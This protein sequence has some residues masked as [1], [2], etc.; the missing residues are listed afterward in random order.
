MGLY[1][2]LVPLVVRDLLRPLKN[3]ANFLLNLFLRIES[4][5]R[6]LS[7]PFSGM[8]FH[9]PQLEYAMLL[10]TW[11]LEL[12][13]VWEKIL[14]TNFPLMV[15]VGAAEGYYA[16][17]MAYRKPDAKVVAYEMDDRVRKNLFAL[18][19]ANQVN[20]EVHGK[21]EPKDLANLGERLEG[22]FILMDVEGYEGVL[23]DPIEIPSLAKAT[24]LVE[25]HD[26]YFK[27][28]TTIIEERFK[29]THEIQ[30]VNGV[31]RTLDH[32]TSSVELAK[33]F[34]SQDRLLGYMDEGRPYEM[35][36]F[37]MV[38]KQS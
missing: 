37:Y 34:F 3:P 16:V 15:D 28:C 5:N 9:Y 23:L 36:W 11:E 18:R 20:L 13:G 24:I 35:H 19:D 1:G 26:M 27:D 38:P 6:V 33:I 8:V 14:T 12:A 30:R 22:A 4:G 17:G 25:L 10:G 21:C 7:G 31:K 29:D 32:L 2:K